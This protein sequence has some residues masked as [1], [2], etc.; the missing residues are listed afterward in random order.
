VDFTRRVGDSTSHFFTVSTAVNRL[1]RETHTA[2]SLK[3]WHNTRGV[4]FLN[5][6]IL[7]L[8]RVTE[9][10]SL[11]PFSS[12][13]FQISMWACFSQILFTFSI[14]PSPIPKQ[15]PGFSYCPIILF[16]R[17]KPSVTKCEYSYMCQEERKAT[18]VQLVPCSRAGKRLLNFKLGHVTDL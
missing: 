6:H 15:E 9:G 16:L 13:C 14:S 17:R 12:S 2:N 3:A 11:A 18:M 5:L 4:E 1:V 10:Q 8:G 7:C